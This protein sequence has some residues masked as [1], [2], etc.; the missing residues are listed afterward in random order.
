MSIA[1]I[2]TQKGV[3]EVEVFEDGV[4][5]DWLVDL[6]TKVPVGTPLAMIRPTSG[7]SAADP[8]TPDASEPEAP[9]PHDP[10]P[11]PTPPENPAQQD[12]APRGPF[13]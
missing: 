6:G 12:P 10:K 11:A 1:A 4:L 3:I 8:D 13:P 7:S 5:E 2:E 9:Q